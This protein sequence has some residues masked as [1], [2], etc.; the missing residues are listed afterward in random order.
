MV[1]SVDGFGDFSSG[2]WGLGENN[3]ISIDNKSFISHSLGSFYQALTQ[4]IG[5]LYY[6]DE[7]KVMGLA[8]YGEPKYMDEM[9]K[10][11]LLKNDGSYKLNLKYFVYHK[12]KLIM[13]WDG[14]S[15][16]VGQLFSSDLE[17]LLG[18]ARKKGDE[19]T[20]KQRYSSFS[21]SH[22]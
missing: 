6:G 8:P 9:R 14:G 20:Q 15:P 1:V 7:Y 19:L 4:F 13:K 16:Y 11:V 3:K 21:A 2:S 22:V 18:P 5:F 10:I 17:E 12:E